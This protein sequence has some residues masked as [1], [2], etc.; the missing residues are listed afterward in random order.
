M[1]YEKTLSKNSESSAMVSIP[2]V[3]GNTKVNK[4]DLLSLD[5]G[6]ILRLDEC[7]F[8]EGNDGLIKLDALNLHVKWVQRG[9]VDI[10]ELKKKVDKH[11]NR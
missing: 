6:D 11:V 10:F 7:F 8:T 5:E 4:K 3:L 9:E 1:R 2:L